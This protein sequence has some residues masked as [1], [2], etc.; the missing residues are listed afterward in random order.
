MLITTDGIV[1]NG[2]RLGGRGKCWMTVIPG[3]QSTSPTIPS[4]GL[5]GGHDSV[6]MVHGVNL[7]HVYHQKYSVLMLYFMCLCPDSMLVC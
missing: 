7:W 3:K 4:I 6:V 1:A 5:N 2:G